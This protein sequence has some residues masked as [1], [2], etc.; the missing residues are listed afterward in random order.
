MTSATPGVT[1]AVSLLRSGEVSARE[2]VGVA[3]SSI[4]R[5]N[6]AV[7]AFVHV[8]GEG[9]LATAADIE[10]DSD[11]HRA[12]GHCLGRAPRRDEEQGDVHGEQDAQEDQQLPHGHQDSFAGRTEARRSCAPWTP[13]ARPGISLSPARPRR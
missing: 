5:L 7:N 12:V 11:V 10:D 4:E 1:E 3:L 9:A 8:D 6:P 13:A 2:L